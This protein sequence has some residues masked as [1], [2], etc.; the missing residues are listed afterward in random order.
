LSTLNP[1]CALII[2]VTSAFFLHYLQRVFISKGKFDKRNIRSSHNTVA[3]RSGGLAIFL[4]IFL[5]STYFYLNNLE[6]FDFSIIVPLMLL[7]VVGLYDD[8]YNMDF[9]LKFIFQIIAAKIFIDNG[10]I[11]ENLHGVFG[12]Y[13]LGRILAQLLTIFIILSIINA[14]NFIDGIDGLALSIVILFLISFESFASSY[15][16]FIVFTQIVVL[17]LIPLFYFN[18][19]SKNKIFLGDSGSLFLGGLVSAYVI[20]ILS[21]NYIIKA[22]FDLHKILFVFS[23]L[24]YPIVDIT[25]VFF[26][27]LYNKKSPFQ[28]DKNHIHHLLLNKTNSHFIT[29][30][31]L[32]LSSLIFLIFI[33]II[34]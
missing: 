23:I 24:I 30:L 18:F 7:V 26:L 31:I 13:E 5:V 11:I 20:F 14:I 19:R 34:F 22:E 4:T 6:V 32:T 28:A 33:Q 17:T 9:K 16:P 15:S 3:T 8:V 27:R 10:L 25:R 21:N 12:V 29:S 1:Y 2:V